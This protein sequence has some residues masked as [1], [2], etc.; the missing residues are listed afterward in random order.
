[1]SHLTFG[2]PPVPSGCMPSHNASD[3]PMSATQ[4]LTPHFAAGC[5]DFTPSIIPRMTPRMIGQFVLLKSTAFVPALVESRM[6]PFSR[7]NSLPHSYIV[8]PY[9]ASVVAT[10]AAQDRPRL[11]AID[12]PV[13]MTPLLS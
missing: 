1:M 8:T 9:G 12:S 4:K 2:W 13:N 3:A 7:V 5:T 11:Y 6:M 10:V